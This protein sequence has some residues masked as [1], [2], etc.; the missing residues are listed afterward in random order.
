MSET[1]FPKLAD[2]KFRPDL[3]ASYLEL[4]VYMSSN[5]FFLCSFSLP[6]TTTA[7]VSE[8]ETDP[9]ADTTQQQHELPRTP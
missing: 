7:F 8:V 3:K 1:W 2:R 4:P 6:W 5:G 9:P